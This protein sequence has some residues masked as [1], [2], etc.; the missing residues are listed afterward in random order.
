MGWLKEVNKEQ[1]VIHGEDAL[2]D[3]QDSGTT[4]EK[5]VVPT[6][7]Q[8]KEVEK[9]ATHTTPQ[10]VIEIKQENDIKED[11]KENDIKEDKKE[12]DI[13]EDK[14]ENDIKDEERQEELI[15]N[16]ANYYG[17]ESK[18]Q[19]YIR[20]NEIEKRRRVVELGKEKEEEIAMLIG[21]ISDDVKQIEIISREIIDKCKKEKDKREGIIMKIIESMI[22]N[23]VVVTTNPN[24]V[25]VYGEIIG[26]IC[27]E[28]KEYR[29]KIIT[30]I[31][32]I[33]P[34][35]N[36]VYPKRSDKKEYEMIMKYKRN[37]SDEK[38]FN[39][40]RHSFKILT[41]ILMS[42]VG[43]QTILLDIVM[44]GMY[45]QYDNKEVCLGTV[46][47]LIGSMVEIMLDE[48]GD[49]LKH[50]QYMTRIIQTIKEYLP[51]AQRHWE[52]KGPQGDYVMRKIKVLL[53]RYEKNLPFNK[54]VVEY[55]NELAAYKKQIGLEACVWEN[56]TQIKVLESNEI[57]SKDNSTT[58]GIEEK[59]SKNT[60]NQEESDKEEY[61]KEENPENKEE[62][63]KEENPEK[64]EEENKDS[65][66]TKE[67]KE[68]EKD[69]EEEKR[70]LLEEDPEAEADIYFKPIIELKEVEQKEME[71]EIVFKERGICVRYDTVNE[72]FKERG[73]GEIEIL[74]H[75]TTKLS[76]VILIR[77]QIFK[78]A[79]D[80]YILPYIKIKEFPNNRRAII[81]SVYEDYA[82][83]EG[84]NT[85]TFGMCFNTEEIKERFIKTFKE[86]QEETQQI[87]KNKEEQQE[88]ENKDSA[89]TKENKEEKTEKKEEKTEKKEE[90]KKKVNV[91]EKGDDEERN[92]KIFNYQEF[93]IFGGKNPY[94][95][96]TTRQEIKI[97]KGN[98]IRKEES[99][100]IKENTEN[101]EIKENTEKKE[102]E[103]K[104]NT[105]FKAFDFSNILNKKTD[106]NMARIN[107]QAEATYNKIEEI[108]IKNESETQ[109]KSQSMNI[110]EYDT[111]QPHNNTEQKTTET[112]ETYNFSHE[113]PTTLTQN[114]NHEITKEEEKR[115]LLEEDPEAE[116][117][118]YFKPIIEL[119][120]VEQKEMEEEIVFKERGICVRYDTVNEEFKERGRGEIEIL[121]HPTTKLSRVILIRDQ[122]FKLACDHYILPYIKIKE[123]PNNRRAI[124]YS[125]YEDYAQDEGKNTITFGMCFNTEEIKERFIKTFKELQEETQ[126]IVNKK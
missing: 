30:K 122:I 38:Y 85:I 58:H 96:M 43:D 97:N 37:E 69:K 101:V 67:N 120:E 116:A 22:R 7:L 24:R 114:E 39:R 15:E 76:R 61:N 60:V 1:A 33:S 110:Q 125:V 16:I 5:H 109:E 42:E 56:T 100:R 95:N 21:G 17:E 49:K 71:E 111:P 90:E 26:N 107:T 11:K 46:G 87:V 124:I 35:F 113:Q 83:D 74:K 82:Q 63:N 92:R 3:C 59:H 102:E 53:Q 117:D 84:K 103:Y 81:Y 40:I 57:L 18:I 93:D 14:K 8:N 126:Q 75:P 45:M 68:E 108:N 13:K 48:C 52:G 98:D 51:I 20:A 28:W 12:N 106:N 99:E 4:T 2:T 80:H 88:E 19:N 25:H 50:T 55:Q 31:R 123:F 89:N 10:S 94:D 23:E 36:S 118:I 72:E 41:G 44:N 77:D 27:F 34:V 64:K 32:S 6:N 54:K 62:E 104:E 70:K 86:L 115:K 79:C 47:D 119:K 9:E 65:A 73:R 121:K 105:E 29:D 112:P 66:N 78:L 91:E